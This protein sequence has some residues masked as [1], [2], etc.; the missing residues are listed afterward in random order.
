MDAVA[1]ELP[2][3]ISSPA[4]GGPPPLFEEKTTTST[5]LLRISAGLWPSP[6][7]GPNSSCHSF[8]SRCSVGSIG[9]T[10]PHTPVPSH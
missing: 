9:H 10:R 7:S 1:L 2:A 3:Y 5:L 4:R 6:E 8:Q